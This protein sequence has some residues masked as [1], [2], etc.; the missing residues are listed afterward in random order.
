M[1]FWNITDHMIFGCDGTG[2]CHRKVTR[3]CSPYIGKN[4]LN[5][6]NNSERTNTNNIYHRIVDCCDT[7]LCTML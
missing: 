2:V 7:I 4:R 1:A 5:I 6:Q 3:I